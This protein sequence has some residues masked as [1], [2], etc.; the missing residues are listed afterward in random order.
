EMSQAAAA[1]AEMVETR[2]D[3]LPFLPDAGELRD[4]LTK[5]PLPVIVTCRPKRQGGL[6]DDDAGTEKARLDLLRRASKFEGVA[7]VDVELDTPPRQRPAKK[8]ILSHHDFEGCPDDLDELARTLERSDA[9]VNKIA[10]TV[11]ACEEALRAFDVIRA[12]KKPTFALAMGEAGLIS[13]ILA[14][15]FGAFGTFASL[16]PGRG[17]APA[18]PTLAEMKKL[19]RWDDISS[20]T[21]VFGVIGGPVAHSLSPAIHNAAFAATGINA[22]YLPLRIEPGA[23]NFRRFMDAVLERPWLVLRGLSVTIPHKENALAYLGAKNCDALA[24]RIGA[25]NTI[26]IDST[27]HLRG[28]NSDYTAA[29]DALCAAMDIKRADLRGRKV[30]VLGAGGA[31]RAIVAVLVHF[32]AEVAIYNRTLTRAEKLAKEFNCRPAPLTDASGAK[33]EILINCTSIGMHP[34]VDDCPLETLPRGVNV[35]FD[36]VYNP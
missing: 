22:V 14:K 25:I 18:Q 7:F 33:P 1:G 6:F 17:S 27:G 5:P 10:F 29:V 32:G 31:G 23:E 15:K 20:E 28:W 3:F 19:Y 36:T 30:A 34:N 26:R 4:L 9:A 24:V 21:A 16:G 35:V 2:L 8:V 12:C 13:R 11:R